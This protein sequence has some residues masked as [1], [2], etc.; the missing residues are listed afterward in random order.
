MATPCCQICLN[1]LRPDGHW[2]WIGPRAD[3]CWSFYYGNFTPVRVWAGD[4]MACGACSDYFFNNPN[5]I[6][7]Q[8]ISLAPTT[9]QED[10]L[11]EAPDCETTCANR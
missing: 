7:A 8:I 6:S 3:M 4:Q 11:V 10:Q 5:K 2:Y 1:T 9:D